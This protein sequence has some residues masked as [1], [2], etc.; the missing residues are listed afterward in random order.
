MGWE[1][2]VEGKDTCTKL[3][4]SAL[5]DKSLLGWSRIIF[6]A[7]HEVEGFCWKAVK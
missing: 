3:H 2:S 7:V 6:S 4:R 5:F 1:E